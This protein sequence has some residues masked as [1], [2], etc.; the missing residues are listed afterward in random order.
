MDRAIMSYFELIL[1]RPLENL[2]TLAFILVG[3]FQVAKMAMGLF[4]SGQK[5]QA[6][7][8]E[9]IT[10]DNGLQSKLLDEMTARR[11]SDEQIKN[12]IVGLLD[13]KVTRIDV[14]TLATHA[15]IKAMA[16]QIARYDRAMGSIYRQLKEKGVL[17]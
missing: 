10:Q 6:G 16:A 11:L 12:K 5:L 13:E 17:A 4:S 2:P 8:Q 1:Q 14:T 7:S 3:F 15:D 9:I